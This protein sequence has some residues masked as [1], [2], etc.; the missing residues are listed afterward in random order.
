MMDLTELKETFALFEDWE[1]RYRFVIEL[2]NDLPTLSDADRIEENLIRGC[3]SQV[4][5]THRRQGDSLAFSIDSD[6]HIV[7]GLSAIVLIAI[8]DRTIAEIIETDIGQLFEEIQLLSHLSPTR[9]NGLRAMIERVRRV[10]Q[11]AAADN[12]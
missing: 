6:A 5:L 1:D 2:G 12:S 4:W 8:N 7:R 10:A 11:N 9:G 3:Q